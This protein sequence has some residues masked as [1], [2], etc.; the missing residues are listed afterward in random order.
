MPT[1]VLRFTKYTVANVLLACQKVQI[2]KVDPDQTVSEED[3]VCPEL[4]SV[5]RVSPHRLEERGIK[6]RIS[7]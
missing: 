4:S 6:C 7:G 5:L 2:N 1:G 3:T